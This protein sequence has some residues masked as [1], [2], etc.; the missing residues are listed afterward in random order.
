MFI[1]HFGTGLAFKSITPQPSL[2]T[3][4]FAA[5][6]IDLIWPILILLGFERVEIDPGNTVVTPL[7][8]VHYPFSHSF[9]GVLFWALVFGGIYY[10]IKRSI[11]NA[12]G[13]GVIVTGHWILDL[14][15]H[16][17]D[18]PLTPWTET[19]VGLGLWNSLLGTIVLEGLIFAGGAYLY[20]ACTRAVN[21]KGSLG[22][23][24]LLGFL[25]AMY[26]GNLFGPP[27]P[28]PKPIAIMGMAQWLLV[29]WGYWIDR[30]REFIIKAERLAST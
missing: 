7:N 30:N 19:K 25:T 5:Q 28:S 10:L 12:I 27:P 6:F 14:F 20:I 4:F 17:P 29:L 1:G 2:G 15:T 22:L 23:Y 21:K 3:L 13:L 18:L 11:K 8:F 9:I 16:R 24:G 26:I